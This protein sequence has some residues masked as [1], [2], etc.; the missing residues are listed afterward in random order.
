MAYTCLVCNFPKLKS[1]PRSASGGGSYEICPACG[2]QYGVDDD[3]LGITHEQ[4]RAKWVAGGAKWSSK[5]TPQPKSWKYVPVAAAPKAAKPAKAKTAKTVK[6][7]ATTPAKKIAK[8][9]I[10]KKTK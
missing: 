2:F 1:P 8:K 3:D 7:K 6:P 9:A 10:K 4:W 5:G